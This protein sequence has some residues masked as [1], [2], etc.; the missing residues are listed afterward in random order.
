MDTSAQRL[1]T[2]FPA[3]APEHSSATEIAVARQ[4]PVFAPILVRTRSTE[5]GQNLDQIHQFEDAIEKYTDWKIVNGPPIPRRGWSLLIARLLTGAIGFVRSCLPWKSKKYYLSIGFL[6]PVGLRFKTCPYFDLPARFRI[7]WTYDVWPSEEQKILESAESHDIKLIFAS[8]RQ[9]TDRLNE[10]S[11]GRFECYWLPEAVELQHYRSK[12]MSERRIDV[13]QFGRCWRKYHDRIEEF[14]RNNGIVY[15][16][17]K[18]KGDVLLPKRAEFLEGLAD[19]RISICVPSAITHPERSGDVSTMT[20]R[21]VESM[22]SKCLVVG[23]APLEMK[24]LFDYNPVIEIDM[25]RPGEQLVD[26]LND[27]P[28]YQELIERNYDYV[29]RHHQWTNRIETMRQ[30]FADFE[31]RRQLAERD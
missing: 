29:R 19:S 24:Y 12:P 22:A 10:I 11:N 20:W 15:R 17:A 3:A 26:L 25:S 4:E 31:R 8:S 18:C 9:G 27:L 5:L 7:L 13:I 23:R 28:R 1:I 16:F 6:F 14:C 2:A 21:Y 30:C